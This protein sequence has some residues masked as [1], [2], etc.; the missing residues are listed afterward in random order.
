MFRRTSLARWL[1]SLGA[2]LCAVSVWA[3]SVP[4]F[5]YALEH[6]TGDPFQAFVFH[7]GPLTESQQATARDLGPDGL[8]GKVRANLSVRTVDLNRNPPPEL[9]ELSRTVEIGALPWLV[10]KFPASSRL[11]SAVWSGPLS[12]ESVG[13]L[14]DSPARKEIV[15]CLGDGQSA[16]WLLLE[17]GDDAKDSAAA[18]LLNE[19]L[20]YLAANLQL[21]KL[22]A[23]DIA[24][25][26]V[27]VGQEGLRLEFSQLRISRDDPRESAF[28]RMLL[29]AEADL[30]N[31][32]SPIVF[33]VFGQGRA[34]YAL[35]GEGIKRETIDQAAMFLIGKCS[36]QVKE[37]NPGIDLLLAADWKGLIKAQSGGIPDLPTMAD[38]T[39]SKPVTVTVSGGESNGPG[40]T[41]AHLK[42]NNLMIAGGLILAILVGAGIFRL[43]KKRS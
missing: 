23:Q 15:Q 4:V 39:K 32:K 24:N 13:L 25:G 21:P 38:L 40:R 30:A 9:S 3:C 19:R 33:P 12:A 14:L 7:R 17:S 27:S 6:W 42:L 26:L 35:V 8:A 10:V 16:V 20:K 22:E 1:L 2:V 43:R 29:G 5:R 28:V 37:Q 34:L 18:A 41:S 36:C 11:K 31:T